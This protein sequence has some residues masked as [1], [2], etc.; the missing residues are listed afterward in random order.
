MLHKIVFFTLSLVILTVSLYSLAMPYYKALPTCQ[1]DTDTTVL[2]GK[3]EV[4]QYHSVMPG[5]GLMRIDEYK[6]SRLLTK[7]ESKVT[8]TY[9]KTF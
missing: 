9:C 3:F 6:V 1:N 5:V 2:S 8:I 7:G 4:K